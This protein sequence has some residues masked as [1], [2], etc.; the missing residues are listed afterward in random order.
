MNHRVNRFLTI[1]SLLCLGGAVLA[2][3]YVRIETG[4]QLLSATN[5]VVLHSAGNPFS[6]KQSKKQSSGLLSAGIEGGYRWSLTPHWQVSA[7]GRFSYLLDNQQKGSLCVFDGQ[8]C[9]SSYNYTY[10]INGMVF[11]GVSRVSYRTGAFAYSV[12]LNV[13]LGLL[14]AT[15]YQAGQDSGGGQSTVHFS[16][17]SQGQLSYGASLGVAYQL[18]Q[19]SSLFVNVGYQDNGEAMLGNPSSANQY[20]SAPQG[21]L[22]QSLSGVIGRLGY[23]FQF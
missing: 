17:D 11:S 21:T 14:T 16:S 13:G 4:Y 10:D 9:Y 2:S 7:G 19:H 23:Q 8:N 22:T 12:A 3:P 6:L 18:V 20:Q 1:S 5:D 15:T